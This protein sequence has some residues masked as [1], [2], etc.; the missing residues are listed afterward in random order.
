MSA[1]AE[2]NKIPCFISNSP[3]D[4]WLTGGP[5]EWSSGMMFYVED[6]LK[7]YIGEM[8]KLDTNKKVGFL[9]DSEV[10][11]VLFSEM[12]NEMLPERGYEIVDP[13]RFA[14]STTDYTNI[15]SQLKNGE[16]DIIMGNQVTPNFTTAW[17]QFQQLGY[18]P[19]AMVIG[20]ALQFANDVEALG[21]DTGVGI[22]SERHWDRSYNLESTL[23]DYN[24]EELADAYD[25]S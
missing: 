24:A 8:D 5:Y 13:G 16:C 21:G 12:L 2:R 7:G 3:A 14:V 1:V 10:D 17:Q 11:G 19:K 22:M 4:S 23:L 9:F 20:K 15:I 18:V 6:L 25:K